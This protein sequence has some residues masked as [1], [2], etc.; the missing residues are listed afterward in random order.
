MCRDTDAPA[1]HVCPATEDPPELPAVGHELPDSPEPE[2]QPL[3]TSGPEDL[4]AW[5]QTLELLGLSADAPPDE[6]PLPPRGVKSPK[7]Q[8][9]TDA[10]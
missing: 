10:P 4:S 3:E 9:A 8:G 2:I 7:P 6:E 1:P 5:Q